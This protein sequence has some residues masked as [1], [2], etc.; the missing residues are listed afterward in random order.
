MSHLFPQ[1]AIVVTSVLLMLLLAVHL[2]AAPPKPIPV[3]E[4]EAA[5]E[6]EM[7][8]YAE[9]LEHTDEKIEMLPIPGGKFTMGSPAGEKGRK[10]DEGP[11]HEVEVGPFWMAKCE[12]PWDV[13]EVWSAD[14][15]IVRRKLASEPETERDKASA[16]FQISQP[17]K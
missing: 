15:D 12:I 14:L 7:K 11:Q 10:E 13:Y 4:A 8:P 3:K 1:S 17:T 16:I 2:S 6:K 5:S 9:L